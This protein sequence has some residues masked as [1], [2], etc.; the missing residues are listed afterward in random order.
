MA[1]AVKDAP[2][3]TD[4][5]LDAACSLAGKFTVES[6]RRLV[7]EVRRLRSDEWL[8]SAITEITEN[9]APL[10]SISG[11][12]EQRLAILRNHRD[13]AAPSPGGGGR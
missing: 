9:T 7:A 11:T 10:Q 4:E 5:E 13:G 3:L 12:I 6:A 1:E 2:P 8:R